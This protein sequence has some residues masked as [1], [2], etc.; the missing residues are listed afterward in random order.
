MVR[1]GGGRNLAREAHTQKGRY[2]KTTRASQGAM[3]REMSTSARIKFLCDLYEKSIQVQIQHLPFNV[4]RRYL[5]LDRGH[6]APLAMGAPTPGVK[7]SAPPEMQAALRSLGGMCTEDVI[8]QES[9]R[10]LFRKEARDLNPALLIA[11]PV[12]A[13]SRGGK[14]GRG[15]ASCGVCITCD[16]VEEAA[17]STKGARKIL[18]RRHVAG[19]GRALLVDVICSARG[20]TG[21]ALLGRLLQKMIAK[22]GRERKEL[23]KLVAVVVS[24]TGA[25]LF[26]S[27]GARECK[28]RGDLLMWI[29]ISEVSVETIEEG[30]PFGNSKDLN[31]LCIRNGLTRDSHGKAFANG[32]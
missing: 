18:E 6:D 21:R 7:A 32:C 13:P 11:H 12:S 5:A 28:F 8:A 2:Y 22:R 26:R 29:P 20:G 25:R 16:F 15:E 24:E 30:L 27:F 17:L 19:L 14:G 4:A 1:M 9:V 23:L 3:P 31:A 10:V